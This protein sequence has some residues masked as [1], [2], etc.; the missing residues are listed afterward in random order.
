M[1]EHDPQWSFASRRDSRDRHVGTHAREVSGRVTRRRIEDGFP[2]MQ[3]RPSA[4]PRSV[5]AQ[6]VTYV[7]SSA[8]SSMSIPPG[9][10]AWTT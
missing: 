2:F 6:R 8:G 9:G 7:A 3:A 10:Q 4:S 1:R 5:L